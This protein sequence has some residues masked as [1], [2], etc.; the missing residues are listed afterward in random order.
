MTLAQQGKLDEA[1][2]A[3][4]Q[5]VG[6]TPDL[7]ATYSNLGNALKD[8]GR[9]EEAIAA[10][11]KAVSIKPDLAEAHSNLGN[12]LRE[13]GKLDEAVL[14]YRRGDRNQAG[15]CRGLFQPRRSSRGPGQA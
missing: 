3:Y 9:L 7:A 15:L 12:A 5:A 2:A 10:Y 14:A 6:L 8:Q 13:Q 11:R 1:I 4:R